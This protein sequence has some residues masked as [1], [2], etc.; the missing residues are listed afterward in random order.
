[1]STIS[2]TAKASMKAAQ[3]GPKDEVIISDAER[4]RLLRIEVA[5]HIY[6]SSEHVHAL[7]RGYDIALEAAAKEMATVVLLEDRLAVFAETL[8]RLT[9]DNEAKDATITQLNIDVELLKLGLDIAV[10]RAEK[11]E[12]AFTKYQPGPEFPPLPGPSP[13]GGY[14]DGQFEEG[15]GEMGQ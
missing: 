7:L 10:K 4:I 13:R 6:P 15:T 9:A 14:E 12:E 3:Q 8:N 5:S 1:M 11:I 2:K